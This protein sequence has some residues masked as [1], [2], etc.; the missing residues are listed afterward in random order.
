[1][2]LAPFLADGEEFL[3]TRVLN[4]LRILAVHTYYQQPGGEDQIF[5]A[6]TETQ[7]KAGH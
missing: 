1:M 2:A 4:M 5:S 7:E 6:E 3:A